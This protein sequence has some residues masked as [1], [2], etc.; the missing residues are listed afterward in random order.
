M[1]ERAVGYLRVST[2]G[3]AEKGMGL[4]AQRERVTAYA[5]AKGWALVDVVEEAASGG[6]LAEEEFSWEHRPAL[7]A[8]MERAKAQGFDVLLVAKLDRLSRDYAT[9]TV[10]E[11]RLQR[12]GVEVVSVAE[13]NG[14]G[15]V[16]EFIRGQLALVA[17]LERAM[18]A[19]RVSAGKAQKKRLGRHIHGRIPYGYTSYE[20]AGIL[21]PVPELETIIRRIFGEIRQ[22]DSPGKVARSLNHDS[23]P[24]PLGRAWTATTVQRI[25]TNPAYAGERHRVRRAHPPIVS[26]QTFNAAQRALEARAEVWAAKRAAP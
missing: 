18:I 21:Q 2:A 26:R 14:D 12:T 7:L 15:P 24:S 8:L 9:L 1:S 11:R 22:G 20:E 25:A 23:I 10:L 5:R 17:Q 16:A 4:A 13:E 6:V 3:Q 19:E